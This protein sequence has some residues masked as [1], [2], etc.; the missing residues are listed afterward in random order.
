MAS[1]FQIHLRNLNN[2]GSNQNSSKS[3][4]RDLETFLMR[5]N[6][7]ERPVLPQSSSFE[8]WSLNEQTDDQLRQRVNDEWAGYFNH[9][10]VAIENNINNL[11]NQFRNDQTLAQ[12]SADER[13]AAV[14]HEYGIA[15][16]NVANDSLRRGLARSSIAVNQQ[17]ALSNAAAEQRTGISN[18]LIERLAGLDAEIH[19]LEG[20]RQSAVDN[21]NI[22]FAARI[23]K[24]LNRLKGERDAFNRDAI[25]FNNQMSQQER[26]NQMQNIMNESR[27]HGERLSHM[28]QEAD[29]NMQTNFRENYLKIRQYLAGMSRRD[30]RDALANDPLFRM[31][32]NS[33]FFYRLYAEFAR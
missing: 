27:L 9:N 7:I 26:D 25:R 18:E 17:A 22:A 16:E 23:T 8:R 12:R 24:E 15:R 10:I 14:E 29:L 6:Q 28:Q 11:Y 21:F 13:R 33:Y 4:R 2:S 19:S 31:H 5:Q 32:L 1:A 3:D 20:M 30:A